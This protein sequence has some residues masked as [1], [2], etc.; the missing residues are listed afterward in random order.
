MGAARAESADASALVAD[1]A[2]DDF[3][4][5]VALALAYSGRCRLDQREICERLTDKNDNDHVYK[6]GELRRIGT[7]VYLMRV[8]RCIS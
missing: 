7:C 3:V 2:I 6:C 8:G 5:D 4:A 1:V